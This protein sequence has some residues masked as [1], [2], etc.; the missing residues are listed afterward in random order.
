MQTMDETAP[1][2]GT[3]LFRMMGI[4]HAYQPVAAGFDID[5]V[6]AE[7]QQLGEDLNCDIDL[8]DLGPDEED[9]LRS[10]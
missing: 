8:K 1:Y 5:K 9:A 7:L 6:K 3:T 10:A 4:A 2:G